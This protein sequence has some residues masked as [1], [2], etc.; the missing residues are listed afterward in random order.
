MSHHFDTKLAK[1]NPAFNICDMYLFKGSPES[2]VMAMTVNADSGIS[3]LDT[4]HPEGLYTFRFDLNGDAREELVFKFRFDEPTHVDGDEHLHVQS[5]RVIRAGAKQMGGDAG[6]VILEGKTGS[7]AS[8]SGI[9]AFV[10]T[11]PELWTANA[12]GF[13]DFMGALYGQDRFDIDAF[14]NP[15]NYFA[16]R[17]V[18]ALVL[19]V[20]D[21]LIGAA[22]VGAWATLSLYGHAPEV[23]IYRWGLPLFTH[24][25][26]SNPERPDLPEKFHNTG[27]AQDLEL[28]AA[29]VSGFVA[30][31]SDRAKS[32][33]EPQAYGAHIASRLC[34]AML[35]YTVGTPAVFSLSEFNG[36]PLGVDAFDVMLTLGANLPIVD[37]VHPES[38]RIQDVFPYYG[39]PYSKVEQAGLAPIS[40]GFY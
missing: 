21:S 28:F 40:T 2:T 38:S 24:L 33:G 29:A 10:G 16:R 35:P 18:T 23:Q 36:R 31:L 5:Y 30:K 9:K 14:K 7:I 27:P 20:P 1:E 19:E 6:E 15:Q 13:F 37:G 39:A 22:K 12:I 25:F 32:T 11:A 4:L 26:L 34:P 8:A 17:N 3:G